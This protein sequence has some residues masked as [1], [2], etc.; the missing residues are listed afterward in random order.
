MTKRHTKGKF[1]AR[2]VP[3]TFVNGVLHPMQMLGC[4]LREDV[5]FVGIAR[6][7]RM[8]DEDF[9]E[10]R[11]N[12]FTLHLAR[13]GQHSALVQA[14]FAQNRN[15]KHSVPLVM[16]FVHS[17]VVMAKN[18][19]GDAAPVL[20]AGCRVSLVLLTIHDLVDEVREF[21]LDETMAAAW[22]TEVGRQHKNAKWF[23]KDRYPRQVNQLLSKLGDAAPTTNL[24]ACQHVPAPV[25][26]E[27]G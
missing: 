27:V 22:R 3:G 5:G 2:F 10:F 18:G 20:R 17:A 12:A 9:Q 6:T 26:A 21:E 14:R 16:E 23:D 15:S 8:V 24:L 25:A 4:V 11:E 13:L 1:P 7:L 19:E